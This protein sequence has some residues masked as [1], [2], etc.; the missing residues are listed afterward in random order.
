MTRPQN[1][2]VAVVEGSQLRL[3]ESLDDGED[4]SVHKPHIGVSVP[5]T[6]FA[7]A[8][9]ITGLQF[10]NSVGANDNVVEEGNKYSRVQAV[11]HPVVHLHQDRR[12]DDQRL[13]RFLNEPA[14]DRVIRIIPIEGGIQRSRV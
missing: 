11:V 4:S 3:V 14:A 1:V 8:S 9:V 12:W 5:V 2:E 13:I 6:Q 10:L 7:D